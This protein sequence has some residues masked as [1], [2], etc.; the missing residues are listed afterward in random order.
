[1]S[2][3]F[4]QSGRIF[5]VFGGIKTSQGSVFRSTVY[6]SWDLIPLSTKVIIGWSKR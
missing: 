5:L 2:Y 6:H 4:L 3:L 1:M